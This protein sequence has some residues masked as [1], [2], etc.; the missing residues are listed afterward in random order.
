MNQDFEKPPHIC[1]EIFPP[2][3]NF[4]RKTSASKEGLSRPV[5]SAWCVI[6]AHLKITAFTHVWGLI[7]EEV[8]GIQAFPF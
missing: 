7:A 6:A 2:I 3:P 5:R 1:T 4:P 8:D